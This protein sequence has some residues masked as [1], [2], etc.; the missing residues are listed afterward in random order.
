DFDGVLCDSV[1]ECYVS[2][3][4]AFFERYRGEQV[5]QVSIDHY[6]RFRAYRPYI[7]SGEDYLLLH[8]LIM[9]NVPVG[10]QVDF[11]A[12]VARAGTEHMATYRALLYTVRDQLVQQSLEKWRAL[13]TAYAGIPE[14]LRVLARDPSV[15]IV[16]TKRQE[17]IVRVLEGWGIRWPVDRISMPVSKSK[18]QIVESIVTAKKMTQALFVDDHEDDLEC[19]PE[20]PIECR[21]AAWGHVAPE[22]LQSPRHELIQLHE[23][24]TIMDARDAKL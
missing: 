12:A 5:A 7:R 21:L 11:D 3:W 23:L 22:T 10:S 14:R 24:L 8:S 16:S 13:H 20:A 15:W 4:I 6:R 1:A 19:R 9:D 2:S 17:F 18:M